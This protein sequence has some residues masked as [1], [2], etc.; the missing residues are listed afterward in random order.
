MRLAEKRLIPPVGVHKLSAQVTS[1]LLGVEKG[2][3]D[4]TIVLH[5]LNDEL[6]IRRSKLQ[7]DRRG[8]HYFRCCG[9]RLY[10][11]DYRGTAYVHGGD[12]YRYH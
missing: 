9:E 3:H 7:Q 2:E 10:L 6:R 11:S 1:Y 12:V 4:D 5:R 8:E